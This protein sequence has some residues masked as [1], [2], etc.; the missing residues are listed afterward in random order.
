M[1]DINIKAN[2]DKSHNTPR[3]MNDNV[4]K[5]TDLSDDV[6][7]DDIIQEFFVQRKQ[8][9]KDKG[10][11]ERLFAQLE[12]MP[13]PV[14]TAVAPAPFSRVEVLKNRYLSKN[15]IIILLFTLIG[16]A[17]FSAFGGYGIVVESLISL[18]SVISGASNITPQLIITLL[19]L[20][21]SLFALGKFAIEAE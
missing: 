17:L 9:I 15:G 11:S 10:F 7:K 20:V 4:I 2:E 14:S 6:I 19:F 16:I 13:K 21:G 18:G 8:H 12:C 5:A 3:D 1:K